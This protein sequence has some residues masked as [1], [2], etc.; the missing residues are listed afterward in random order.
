M[1][2]PSAPTSLAATTTGRDTVR[3]TWVDGANT[4]AFLV[5]RH[6][7]DVY[8]S[9][10][11]VGSVV[12]GSQLYTDTGLAP[13]TAYY[14]WL[15]PLGS[16][17]V[18]S[19]T[20]SVTATTYGAAGNIGSDIIS[21]IVTAAKSRLVS[22][23][24]S[25]FVQL[26]WVKDIKKNERVPWGYGVDIGNEEPSEGHVFGSYTAD[27]SLKVVLY[28][29]PNA[30][31]SDR[32]TE[33]ATLTLEQWKDRVHREFTTTRLYESDVI[34]Q[35][36]DPSTEPVFLEDAEAVALVMTFPVTYRNSRA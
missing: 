23:L 9:A 32:D 6:T 12:S 7:A 17:G 34:V 27:I 36:K 16:G 22:V 30:I 24:S 13:G 28:R 21:Q 4:S 29:N 19:Q 10:S 11:V 26:K 3:L 14:Y 33:T 15:L 1:P 25:D 35:I 20:S 5:Y 8:G 18:G 2:V 31:V